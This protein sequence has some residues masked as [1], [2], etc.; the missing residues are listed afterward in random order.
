MQILVFCLLLDDHAALLS[1]EKF[2][3]NQFAVILDASV[4]FFPRAGELLV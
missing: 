4:D 3:V 1:E 2:A